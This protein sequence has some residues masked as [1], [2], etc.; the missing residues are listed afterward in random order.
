MYDE[1]LG[2]I[3]LFSCNFSHKDWAF[4]E[5]KVRWISE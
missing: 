5:G 1:S 3:Q 4:Y 2:Q